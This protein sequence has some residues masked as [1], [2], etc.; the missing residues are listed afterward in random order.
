MLLK[1]NER[2]LNILIVHDIIFYINFWPL[3]PLVEPFIEY[4]KLV[5]RHQ[6]FWD[7]LFLIEKL[8]ISTQEDEITWHNLIFFA[9]HHTDLW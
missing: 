2:F 5:V 9:Y 4:K 8:T 3:I 1:L 7:G 6:L